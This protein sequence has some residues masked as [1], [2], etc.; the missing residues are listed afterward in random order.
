MIFDRLDA[1]DVWEA[2]SAVLGG[3]DHVAGGG[4][5][6]GA[7]EAV[8]VDLGDDGLGEVPELAPLHVGLTEAHELGVEVVGAVAVG[9]LGKCRSRRRRLGRRP[10]G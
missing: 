10:S 6:G 1:P 5:V 8:A 4:E 2:E 9:R 7:G 3:D